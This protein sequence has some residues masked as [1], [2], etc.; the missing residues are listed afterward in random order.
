MQWICGRRTVNSVAPVANQPAGSAKSAVAAVGLLVGARSL[1]LRVQPVDLG[2]D[3]VYVRT[4]LCHQLGAPA[5]L[6][7][8][9]VE[10]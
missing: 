3:V 1:L 7:V 9:A 2:E 10:V 8:S 5:L 6:R 4:Y